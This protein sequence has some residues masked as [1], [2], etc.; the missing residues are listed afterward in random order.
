MKQNF[1]L[2][3][4]IG[5]TQTC[6]LHAISTKI[7]PH[8]LLWASMRFHPLVLVLLSWPNQNA[9]RPPMLTFN[10]PRHRIWWFP[11]RSKNPYT[12]ESLP[13]PPGRVFCIGSYSHGFPNAY[14]VL[15]FPP[16][17]PKWRA[18]ILPPHLANT[19][20]QY[21]QGVGSLLPAMLP[22]PHPHHSWGPPLW[23]PS[24]TTLGTWAWVHSFLTMMLESARRCPCLLLSY[25]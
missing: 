14:G 9:I 22:P 1:T 4:P 18:A 21:H 23:R 3:G 12:T 24:A 10:L 2:F 15:I 5:K 17:H 13:L 19:S 6:N 20:C 25:C 7:I 11:P 8:F 16:P